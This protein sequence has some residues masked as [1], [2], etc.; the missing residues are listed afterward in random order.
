MVLSDEALVSHAFFIVVYEAH[1]QVLTIR[2]RIACYISVLLLVCLS[3]YDGDGQQVAAALLINY[4]D[5][6]SSSVLEVQ[7]KSRGWIQIKVW[8]DVGELAVALTFRVQHSKQVQAVG[9]LIEIDNLVRDHHVD[10]ELKV[11]DVEVRL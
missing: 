7:D 11:L 9:V 6:E 5:I 1:T 4:L 3:V 10:L 2:I 8:N